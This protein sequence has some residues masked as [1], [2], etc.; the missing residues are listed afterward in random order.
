[1]PSPG[2]VFGGTT[3]LTEMGGCGLGVATT[4]EGGSVGSVPL[5]VAGAVSCVAARYRCWLMICTSILRTVGGSNGRT[6]DKIPS[7]SANSTWVAIEAPIEYGQR[8]RGE[9]QPRLFCSLGQRPTPSTGVVNDK[10][11]SI[12]PRF[13]SSLGEHICMVRPATAGARTGDFR[14]TD[15]KYQCAI[16]PTGPPVL[17]SSRI[18]E[19]YPNQR[20]A[21]FGLRNGHQY[22]SSY[23]RRLSLP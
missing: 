17:T 11:P 14:D 6:A 22:I 18:I 7:A 5:G 13:A 23:A 12:S 19:T 9:R 4:G 21:V 15:N 10:I 3:G 1:M 20:S 8:L 16:S 2:S